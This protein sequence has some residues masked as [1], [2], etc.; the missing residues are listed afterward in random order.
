M[1]GRREGGGCEE[2][3]SGDGNR[4]AWNR[5]KKTNMEGR[6]TDKGMG[7]GIEEDRK[8]TYNVVVIYE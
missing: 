6:I 4:G 1:K 3:R 7:D 5:E 8:G 2:G